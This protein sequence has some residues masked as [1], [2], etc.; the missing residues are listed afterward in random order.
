MKMPVVI[1]ACTI[2][3]LLRIDDEDNFLYKHLTSL[4]I[5]MASTVY[6]EIKKNIFRNAIDGTVEKRIN[7][8]LPSLPSKIIL[9]K[10]TEITNDIGD[11]YYKKICSF[12]GH[13]KKF[14][15]ELISSVL[16][17]TLSRTEESKVCFFTDDFPAKEEFKQFFA[18]QQIGFIED[19]IDLL[20]MLYWLKENFTKPK[21]MTVLSDLKAEYNR[22]QKSFVENIGKTKSNF[23]RNPKIR[24]IINEIENSF[25]NKRD[26]KEYRNC[27]VELEKLN[28][29]T[30]KGCLSSFPNLLKQ[31]EIVD[32]I[33]MTLNEIEN[34]YVYKI[35]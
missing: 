24:S 22:I 7:V 9:H 20:L 6:E 34:L 16:A 5:H 10:D 27:L 3:N 30:I 12:L 26:V 2:I 13:T 23:N 11:E 14:N 15:G 33:D 29:K 28:D 32:K 25:Y 1:D 21:L 18:I 4:D 35:V 17:L 19:S 8:L 31:P